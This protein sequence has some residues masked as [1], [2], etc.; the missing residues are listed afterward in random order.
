MLINLAKLS[1]VVLLSWAKST[2]VVLRTRVMYV[3]VL[4]VGLVDMIR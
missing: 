2:N 4:V 1:F 3:E